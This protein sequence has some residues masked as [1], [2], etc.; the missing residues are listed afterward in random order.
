MAI[1]HY[2]ENK[3]NYVIMYRKTST[4]NFEKAHCYVS[5]NIKL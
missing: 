4:M 3:V 2:K 5:F 1:K